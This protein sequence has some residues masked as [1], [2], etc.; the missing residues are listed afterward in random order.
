MD[1]LSGGS[2]LGALTLGATGSKYLPSCCYNGW[3][4]QTPGMAPW[5]A[6]PG[7][8]RDMG[9]LSFLPALVSSSVS[10]AVF[11]SRPC[12]PSP[13]FILLIGEQFIK[14]RSGPT[15]ASH[16]DNCYYLTSDLHTFWTFS[17]LRAKLSPH[18]ITIPLS[19]ICWNTNWFM[20]SCSRLKPNLAMGEL[21]G[22]PTMH[23][24]PAPSCLW[25]HAECLLGAHYHPCPLIFVQNLF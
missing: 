19:S 25:R 14:S 3:A 10:K 8:R 2:L 16:G 7:V 20:F 18:Y 6:V 4:S 23:R 11:L 21:A 1:A 12:S 22:T 15:Q 24:H 13:S 17:T 9:P 5:D